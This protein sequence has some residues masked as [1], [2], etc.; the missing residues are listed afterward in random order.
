MTIYSR[1]LGTGSYLPEKVLSNKDLEKIVDTTDEWITERTGI[2]NRHIIADHETTSSMAEVAS[3]RA[4]EAAGI[5]KEEIELIIT[6]TCTPD[7]FFPSSSCILQSRLGL[8]TFPAFDVSAACAGFIYGLSI[9]DKFIKTGAV[10][11]AL[12]VGA[13]SLTRLV[14]WSD[15]STC[16]LFSDGAGAVVLGAD[17]QPGLISTHIH[18]DGNYHNLLY[19]ANHIGELKDPPHITMKGSEVFKLAVNALN[20]I[21]DETLEANNM[22]RSEIDWLIPHQANLRIIQATAKKLNLPMERVVLTVQDQGNTSSA[23]IPL[24]LDIAVRDGRIKR[25]ETLL[26]NAF[27]AGLT[28]GSALIRY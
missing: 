17:S 8:S 19:A 11:T 14:D 9:A 21:V 10:K 24:A 16:I 28:W 4:I 18:A 6:G 2:S 1:I 12:V 20:D 26:F 13:E 25:G 7:R 22:D 3:R 5:R 27:G 23:S 15:R